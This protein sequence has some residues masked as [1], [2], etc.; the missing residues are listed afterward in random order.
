MNIVLSYKEFTDACEW[1]FKSIERIH[2]EELSDEEMKFLMSA[3]ER[4]LFKLK[5]EVEE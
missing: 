1:A 3:F 5:I 4:L 2:A